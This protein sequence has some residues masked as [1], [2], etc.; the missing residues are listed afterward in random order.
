MHSICANLHTVVFFPEYI[1]LK[2][3][4]MTYE[5]A[6]QDKG[7]F[8][9]L[10]NDWMMQVGN[11]KDRSLDAFRRGS[12]KNCRVWFRPQRLLL[13]KVKLYSASTVHILFTFLTHIL[14]NSLKSVILIFPSI[15][16]INLLLSF[17]APCDSNS[18]S[19][20]TYYSERSAVKFVAISFSISVN[21]DFKKL[22]AG[23]ST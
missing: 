22:F 3:L 17:Q 6:G 21:R 4:L 15:V 16:T 14:T 11:S 9:L 13:K 8:Y 5:S 1:I 19:I 18:D 12:G 23:Y 10:M 7:L 2:R 20:P